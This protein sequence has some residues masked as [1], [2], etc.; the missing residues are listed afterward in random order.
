[1][2]AADPEWE[3]EPAMKEY[4]TF[5]SK[6]APDEKVDDAYATYAYSEAQ[7]LVEL[8]KRC[9]DRLTREN[10]L[11]QATHIQD[12]Q[13]PL[14]VPG[15][16]INVTPTSRLGWR[17]AKIVRFD[18]GKWIYSVNVEAAPESATRLAD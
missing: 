12:F 1:M 9:G 5:M 14:F 10:L 4:I 13:L 8:I 2:Q 16:K 15:V 3:D 6:W 18:G 11:W 7:L 17:Q